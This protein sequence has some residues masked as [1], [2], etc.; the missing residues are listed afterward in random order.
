MSKK[1][2]EK[3]KKCI[4]LFI[5]KIEDFVIGTPQSSCPEI[6]LQYSKVQGL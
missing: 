2:K 5:E 6:F 1:K 3:K 4:H